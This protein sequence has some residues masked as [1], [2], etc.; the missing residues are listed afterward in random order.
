[1]VGIARIMHDLG[2]EYEDD[3]DLSTPLPFS[4]ECGRNPYQDNVKN[5]E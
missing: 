3:D 1:M 2:W 5:E 4:S